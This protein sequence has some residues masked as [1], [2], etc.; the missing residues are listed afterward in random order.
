MP[1]RLIIN[2]ASGSNSG[3]D[4]LPRINDRL[5]EAVGD[6]DIVLTTG[7]GDATRAAEQAARTG[8]ER[9][10]A[11]GGDGTLNEVLNGLAA[12][13]GALERVRVGVVPLGTGNDFAAALGIPEDLEEALE[14][15]A[16]AS[17][18]TVDLGWLDDR[19]FVNVSAGGFIAEV[20]DATNTTLKTLAGKLAYLIG[21]ARVLFDYQPCRA[22][23]KLHGGPHDVE[24]DV[25]VQ[26]F[27]VCNSR[28][29]GG[30]RLI[31]PQALIDDGL[32]DVC[33]IEAMPTVDFVTL[34]TRVA[35]GEHV[36]DPRV[37]YFTASRAD[38]A[39]DR[40]VKINTD[41]EV[42]ETERCTYTVMPRKVRFL[43]G[44]SPYSAR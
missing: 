26:T 22:R 9:V 17:E 20:S 1:S 15:A 16:A 39:F 8:Y 44:S 24:R 41:G 34:L 32:L 35:G 42:L 7:A 36:E 2:P 27:A 10:F 37:L 18:L 40:T 33:V 13:P 4:L 6:L 21:G 25:A 14:I 5:R 38:L 43:A 19:A 3:L 23:L 12:V 28:L 29:V 31:A 30:G 11:A